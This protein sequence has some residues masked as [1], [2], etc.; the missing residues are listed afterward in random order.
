[1][2]DSTYLRILYTV[3]CLVAALFWSHWFVFAFAL[4]GYI[5]FDWYI[6]GVLVLLL[7]DLLFSTP[8]LRFHNFLM[9]GTVIGAFL[10][11]AVQIAKRFTRY[12]L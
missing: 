10:F 5:L 9:V 7:T 6:E 12:G 2:I 3:F 1:M 11:A 8:L 4:V